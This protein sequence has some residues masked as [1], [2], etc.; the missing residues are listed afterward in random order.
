MRAITAAQQ[1]V[2]D[3]GN[4]AEWVRVQ[5][6]DAGGTW[7]DLTTYPGFNAL[8]SITWTEQ[9]DSPQATFDCELFRELYAFNLS[10]V[11]RGLAGQQGLR[12]RRQ[13]SRRCSI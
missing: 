10:P 9:I 13:R 5:V 1:G 2:L 3:A 7:R 11:R 4:Q 8:K 12:P 6:K